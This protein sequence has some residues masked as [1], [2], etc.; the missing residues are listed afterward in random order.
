M[1]SKT[2]LEKRL[3][4]RTKALEKLY[5]AYTALVDGGVK[6]YMIDDRQLTRF[7]LP[8][9]SEE[10]KTMESEIDALEAELA[11]KKRRKAFGVIPRDW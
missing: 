9:L 10:I 11:G 2:I 7:D 4:F 6:S 3:T 1:A 8:A 5:D